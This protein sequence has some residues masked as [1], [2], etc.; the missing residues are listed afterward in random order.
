MK[1][2]RTGA[3]LLLA[4]VAAGIAYA[5]AHCAGGGPG[6]SGIAPPAP[7]AGEGRDTR[8]AS[9]PRNDASALDL[10]A[11]ARTV[12]EQGTPDAARAALARIEA[13]PRDVSPEVL[14]ELDAM[15]EA[16]RRKLGR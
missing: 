11:G 6:R 4:L 16:L 5:V 9:R 10:L 1:A 13:S 15:R 2:R 3:M 14:R 7:R 8:P 12:L